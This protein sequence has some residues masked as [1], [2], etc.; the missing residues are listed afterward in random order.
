MLSSVTSS[1]P[2]TYSAEFFGALVAN[3]EST[4]PAESMP[5]PSLDAGL[6]AHASV[7]G[8]ECPLDRR[9]R[10]CALLRPRWE[11]LPYGV[12][13]HTLYGPAFTRFANRARA[14]NCARV[15]RGLFVEV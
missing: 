2:D 15:V 12:L 10:R 13:T 14:W 8:G 4:P 9:R 6:V 11:R 3:D 7:G 5:V 1:F